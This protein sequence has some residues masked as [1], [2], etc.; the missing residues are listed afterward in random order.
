MQKIKIAGG[1]KWY[2]IYVR[3]RYEKKTA[4]QLQKIGINVYC[5]TVMEIHQWSDRKKKVEVPV[6]ST[7]VFVQLL[8]KERNIIF[9]VPGVMGYLK[10]LGQPAVVRD[11][12]IT[13]I[14][15]WLEKDVVSSKI[16][17]IAPGDF[18]TIESGP[19]KGKKGLAQQVG[20][21]KIQILLSDFGL[22]ITLKY[23]SE[24]I[25]T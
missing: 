21:H 3:P 2:V 20:N 16:E 24:L 8:E 5:P 15:Q 22:K 1:L 4:E 17:K 7:Y 9:D 11:E 12:E 13:L 19:F 10:W 6:F 14:K 25:L 23:Q 18:V